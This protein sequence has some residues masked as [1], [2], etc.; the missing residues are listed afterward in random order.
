MVPGN[1]H[2]IEVLRERIGPDLMP[3]IFEAGYNLDFFDDDSFKQIGK[4]ENG[5]V[6]LGKNKYKIVILPY[7]GRIP[8]ETYQKLEEFVKGGGILVATRR[9]PLE[10]PGFRSTQE[11]HNKII[12][13]SKRLFEG[14][15]APAHFVQDEKNLRATLNKLLP[16]DMALSTPSSDIGFVHRT[17]PDAD[18]YFVANT[19]NKK[20][21][22]TA[23]FRVSGMKAESWNP[24]DGTV[25]GVQIGPDSSVPLELEP[26]G[27]RLV[28]F[29]KRSLTVPTTSTAQVASPIDLSSGWRVAFGSASPTVWDTLRSW[30]DNDATRYYSG[31]AN[32]E[33]EVT[34]PANWLKK[35][36]AALLDFG[37][38]TALP[39][40][41]LRNGM[42]V[43]LE[44]P[45]REA[46]VVY[47]NDKRA[48]SVWCPP[49]SVDVSSFLKTG[50]NKIRIEVANTA[51]NYMAGH[52]LPDY[53]LLN[54]R[55]GERFTPQE[56]DKIQVLPSGI[57][58]PVRLIAR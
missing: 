14:A 26:Y 56:M 40:Q 20:Q 17:T 57:L 9:T 29:S 11:D 35:D 49:Y 53:R 55:Y 47:V 21:Q 6:V 44:G 37:E 23:K 3:A 31:V 51:M 45:I 22:L 30:S 10:L 54:L 8:I 33:K 46:A 42:Q 52:S 13:I 41:N 48:G 28:I 15:N 7:V 4:V 43:W 50:P 19:T 18:I 34:V 38:G 2:L 5:S 58:G 27:S 36:Q 32:Y 12:E 16:A 1:P 24:F 25:K 39:V